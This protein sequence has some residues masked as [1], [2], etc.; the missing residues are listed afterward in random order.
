ML[1]KKENFHNL[2]AKRNQQNK[3]LLAF[4]FFAIILLAGW[5][6]FLQIKAK[7]YPIVISHLKPAVKFLPL[8][9]YQKEELRAVLTILPEVLNEKEKTF[10]LVFQDPNELRP[11]GGIIE[12]FGILKYLL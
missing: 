2:R 10:L 12:S 3:T 7:G 6:V 5:F 9:E 8:K 11:G 4:W 1:I